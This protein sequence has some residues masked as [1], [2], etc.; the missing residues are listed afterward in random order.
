MPTQFVNLQLLF[1]DGII[2][3]TISNSFNSES[4]LFDDLFARAFK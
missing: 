2:N 1:L 3:L 4:G